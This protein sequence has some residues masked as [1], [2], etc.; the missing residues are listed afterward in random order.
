MV[1]TGQTAKI[2]HFLQ[3]TAMAMGQ[4][5]MAASGVGKDVRPFCAYSLVVE[6]LA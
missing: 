5:V 2:G 1:F 4:S 3:P 6:W